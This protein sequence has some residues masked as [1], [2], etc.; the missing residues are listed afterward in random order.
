MKS[1]CIDNT[2][3]YVLDYVLKSK[4]CVQVHMLHGA[5]IFTYIWVIVRANGGKYSSTM[6][7]IWE[8]HNISS[9]GFMD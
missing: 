7:C 9:L 1:G 6:G 4:K 2:S 3:D 5:G 8:V